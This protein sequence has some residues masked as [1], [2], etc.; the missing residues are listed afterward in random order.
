MKYHFNKIDNKD[1]AVELSFVPV[2]DSIEYDLLEASES[3]SRDGVRMMLRL[4]LS[5]KFNQRLSNQ[6]V[7]EYA[8]LWDLDAQEINYDD[9][10]TKVHTN[11]AYHLGKNFYFNYSL[12]YNK[13]ALQAEVYRIQ[14]DNTAQSINFRYLI[15][16]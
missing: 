5:S 4:Y 11:F 3:D 15:S 1:E 14:K 9:T 10:N 16:L 8:P 2:F 7:L 13:D 12:E 6:T